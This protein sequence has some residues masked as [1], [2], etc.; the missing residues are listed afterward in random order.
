MDGPGGPR[1]PYIVRSHLEDNKGA[2]LQVKMRLQQAITAAKL[3]NLNTMLISTGTIID[4]PDC[5]RGCR[6]KITTRVA[7]AKKVMNNY[8]GGL[9]RVIVY[10]DRVSAV[11]DLAALM[12]L[13]VVE[14]C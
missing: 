7:D 3:V 14:E 1:A 8:S 4:N 10:G 9:H 11:R 13:N 5:D 12:K 6:T 2:S